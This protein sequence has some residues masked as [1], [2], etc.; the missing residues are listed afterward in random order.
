MS[1]DPIE[2]PRLL[3][4]PFRPED[5]E[6][7]FGWLGDAA[8]MRFTPTGPD[9]SIDATRTRI[10]GYCEHQVR[11][12]FSKWLIQDKD[13]GEAIGDS[14]LLLLPERG[15]PDLGFRFVRRSW[16]RGLATEV[17]TAWVRAAFDRLGL[18]RLTAFAHFEN[19]ASLRV[20]E[21]AGFRSQGRVRVRDMDSI[22]FD[23]TASRYRGR[24]TEG[25]ENGTEEAP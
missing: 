5:A 16:G 10:V 12:G 13:T 21:K 6:R 20:L 14:G 17:A 15:G 2:T 23:L 18:A 3:L 25:R 11:Y 24:A 22:T 19:A 8:V 4:R 1:L 9:P 7:A